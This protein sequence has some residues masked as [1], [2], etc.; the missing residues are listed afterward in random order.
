MH[1]LSQTKNPKI[2][3][4][5]YLLNPYGYYTCWYYYAPMHQCT[6]ETVLHPSISI[7][8]EMLGINSFNTYILDTPLPDNWRMAIFEK[9]EGSIDLKE[10]VN[11]F[12]T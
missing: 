10:H 7:I 3:L 4:P 8:V 11:M 6:C 12:V 1:S 9:Y 5:I 2:K